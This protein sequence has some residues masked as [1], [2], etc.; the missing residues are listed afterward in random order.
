MSNGEIILMN[1]LESFY[2]SLYDLFNQ[3]LIQV[4]G[5]NIKELLLVLLLINNIIIIII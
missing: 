1:N 3:T 5:K 4:C 2:P